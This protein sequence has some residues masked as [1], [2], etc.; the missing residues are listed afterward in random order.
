M[1]GHERRDPKGV[2]VTMVM[3]KRKENDSMRKRED[4]DQVNG[5]A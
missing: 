2:Q 4:D 5:Q 1:F 3:R